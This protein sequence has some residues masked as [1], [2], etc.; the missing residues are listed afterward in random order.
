M[1]PIEAEMRQK[2]A[3]RRRRLCGPVPP[4]RVQTQPQIPAAAIREAYTAIRGRPP[5]IGLYRLIHEAQAI[6][7]ALSPEPIGPA[8]VT[9]IMRECCR[10]YRVSTLDLLSCQRTDQIL[11]AR[12]VAIYLCRT[13]TGMSMPALGRFFGG[14][15][16]TTILNASRKITARL[17]QDKSLAADVKAIQRRLIEAEG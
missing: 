17:H 14:R 7:A 10:Y 11:T 13:M 2:A 8:R 6:V 9:E 5:R 15:D 1:G 4:Q 16:H 3:E 12:W